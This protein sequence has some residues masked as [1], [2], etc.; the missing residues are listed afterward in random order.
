MMLERAT[1]QTMLAGKREDDPM[2]VRPQGSKLKGEAHA[3]QTL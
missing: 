3:R 2:I 1:A